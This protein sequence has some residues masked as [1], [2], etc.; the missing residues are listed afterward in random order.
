MQGVPDYLGANDQESDIPDNIDHYCSDD[1]CENEAEEFNENNKNG[2]R[3]SNQ[4][5]LYEAL[6]QMK[7]AIY[8]DMFQTGSSEKVHDPIILNKYLE[9]IDRV[10]KS[11]GYDRPIVL[12][13]QA[14]AVQEAIKNFIRVLHSHL[15]GSNT[16]NDNELRSQFLHLHLHCYPYC[17][18]EQCLSSD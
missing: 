13:D 9:L 11:V 1:H 5:E 17:M 16:A 3:F 12:D 10:W 14:A 8:M 15:S 18:N 4:D 7:N 6:S 2:M